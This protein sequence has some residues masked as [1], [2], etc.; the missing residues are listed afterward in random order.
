LQKFGIPNRDAAP[1]DVDTAPS[2]AGNTTP[3]TDQDTQP[4]EDRGAPAADT[5]GDVDGTAVTE[6]EKEDA[7]AAVKTKMAQLEEEE[8]VG[9]TE[10][11]LRNGSCQ[12]IESGRQTTV[13]ANFYKIDIDEKID[14]YEYDILDIPIEQ[15][16][17]KFKKL[18]ENMI[19]K[20]DILEANQPLFATDHA[21]TIISWKEL[22]S[23]EQGSTIGTFDV[24]DGKKSD[25]TVLTRSLSLGYLRPID[26]A[27]IRKYVSGDMADAALWDSSVEFKALNILVFKSLYDRNV[28]RLGT[29]KFFVKTLEQPL[30]QSLVAMHAYFYTIK[31]FGGSI[32]LN[33]DFGTSTFYRSQLVSDFLNDTQTFRGDYT[34]RVALAGFSASAG[35]VLSWQDCSRPQARRGRP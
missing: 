2:S 8:P 33:V 9:L 18:F 1:A 12:T 21:T 32:L 6:E 14:I 29:N 4:A 5:S 23:A 30:A 3:D 13:L 22:H 20:V 26:F 31:P 28:V 17:K 10:Y 11:P 27:K 19:T 16:K 24:P 25:G 7:N 15:N 35:P 34:K